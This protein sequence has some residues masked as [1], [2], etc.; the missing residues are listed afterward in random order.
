MLKKSIFLIFVGISFL[1]YSQDT[2]KVI[3]ADTTDFSKYSL[4]ELI[5]LKSSYNSTDMEKLIN[6][7]IEVASRKPLSIKKSPSVVSVITDEDINKSGARDL[8]DI[9]QTV[10]GIELNGDVFESVSISIRGL[11]A[12]EG[13]VLLMIDGQEM[14]EID[15]GTVQLFQQ[16]PIGQIKKIEIIR[17]PGSANY[18]GY[19]EL[20]VINILTKNA[21]DLNGFHLSSTVGQT[22][23]ATAREN[24]TIAYGGKKK[25]FEYTISGYANKG[26]FSNQIYTDVYGKSYDLSKNSNILSYDLNIGLKYKSFSV[27]FIKNNLYTSIRD[28]YGSTLSKT[29]PTNYLTNLI[30]LKYQK[31]LT[32]KFQ[33][34]SKINLKLAQPW[35]TILNE[36]D[37]L[38]NT[39]NYN[40]T[41]N[42]YR[43]N[44]T[45]IWDLHR[46]INI[47]FGIDAYYDEAIKHGTQLFL[48]DSTQR[49]TYFNH[50]PF[51]Q[52]LFK[53]RFANITAGLRYDVN[54]AFGSSLNPRL[55]ITKKIGILNIKALYASS[56]R[57]PSIENIQS[58]YSAKILPEQTKTAELEFGFQLGKLS[59]LTLNAFDITTK[60]AINYVV[61]LDS[62]NYA[63]GYLNSAK[64]IGSQGF[65]IEY[66]LKSTFGS[67]SASYSF[68]TVGNKNI[69]EYQAIPNRRNESLG[70]ANH[71]VNIQT[72]ININTKLFISSSLN[73][74]GERFGY[75]SIDLN[76]NGIISKYAPQHQLNIY[77]GT[78]NLKN[79]LNFGLGIRNITNQKIYYIQPYNGLHNSLIGMGREFTMKISYSFN[80]KSK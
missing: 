18:G 72:T 75:T 35:Q 51:I 27:R 13:K 40:I 65:E 59:Y 29:I 80:K 53:T 63:A 1:T 8:I 61:S 14:N 23:N 62:N 57:A 41:T 74:I 45:G 3:L 32:K 50:A 39:F 55:G 26:I 58:S 64:K 69:N 22:K 44:A 31:Q 12:Q 71:K 10:P 46:S 15:Y 17:G 9:L 37:S 47:V 36:T 21:T 11:S 19:A 52:T 70:I 24:I 38:L 79:G 28:G 67:I 43:F 20:L 42:R 34:Q 56:F 33:L 6:S 66:K 7:S 54:T 2:S 77:L 48:K 60:N 49:V 16:Y 4:E 30:E 76:G 73:F 25:D 5:K 68:Y 78:M